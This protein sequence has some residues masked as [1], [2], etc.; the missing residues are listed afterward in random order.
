M[1]KRQSVTSVGIA[2]LA[3]LA[4]LLP[5]K[6]W[7]GVSATVG[8]SGPEHLPIGAPPP[9]QGVNDTPTPTVTPTYTATPTPTRTPTA[10]PSPTQTA[11]PTATPFPTVVFTPSW[12]NSLFRGTVLLQGRTAHA[13][14]SIFLTES[15]CSGPIYAPAVAVTGDDGYFEIM[16]DPGRLFQCLQVFH[17]GY[18]RGQEEWPSGRMGTIILRAGDVTGDN[19]ID[20][21]DLDVVSEGFRSSNSTADVNADGKVDIL[22]LSLVSGNFN[23]RGPVTNW[24]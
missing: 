13:G 21:A 7:P 20:N 16:S 4:L 3:A 18:L 5:G 6:F 9:V 11:T 1:N 19:A 15:A 22:D 2:A 14:T 8:A 10:T 17:P 23:W 12:P 24:R